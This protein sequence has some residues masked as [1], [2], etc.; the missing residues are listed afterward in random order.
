MRGFYRCGAAAVIALALAAA[1][2]CATPI[3][4]AGL[5]I[6][7]AKPGQEERA[8]H[9]RPPFELATN[10]DAIVRIVTDVTCTG[11]L[12]TEDLVLTAHHCVAARD[13]N[14]R[15]LRRDQEPEAI[16]IELG[17]DH[18]PWGDATVR[19][20]V[21]PDCGYT[22]GEGDIALLVLSRRL[23]GIPTLMPRI[24]AQPESKETVTPYG[25]GR[26]AL[27]RDPVHLV[28]RLGGSI[29][30]LSPG[31]FVATASICPGD[32]GGPARSDRGGDVVGV[33]SSS[34]MDGDEHT[35]GTSYFT[36]LD[37]WPELFSA[38]REIAAGASPSELPPYRSCLQ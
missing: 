4:N 7:A 10:E 14:G 11:T 23:I 16:T 22:S 8:V 15:T 13:E 38:A 30:R 27:S 34:V 18:L 9:F 21:S 17:G 26:C 37:V 12:I 25:F 33:I 2:G 36:R 32:S 20:V 31:H 28:P 5:P 35:T 3:T 19:A 24:E 6:P 1:A 29:D